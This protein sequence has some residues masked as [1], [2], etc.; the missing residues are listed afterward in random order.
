MAQR[1]PDLEDQPDFTWKVVLVGNKQVGKTSISNRY[2]E[3]TFN[4]EYK[5]STEVKFKRKNVA[6]PGTQSVAQLHIWDT[7]GQERF[8]SLGPIFFRRSIAALL[9]YDVCNRD[10]FVACESW[11]E[12]IKDNSDENVVI[13]LVGNKVDKPDKVITYDMGSEYAR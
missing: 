9:V 7:L 10:S 3:G 6:V 13:I 4:E 12:Q 1:E 11:S 2:V 8:K 5:T